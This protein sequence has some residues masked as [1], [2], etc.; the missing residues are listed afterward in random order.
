M[1]AIADTRCRETY[2]QGTCGH[3]WHNL[4][5]ATEQP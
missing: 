1:F 5:A 3:A 4:T 2:C